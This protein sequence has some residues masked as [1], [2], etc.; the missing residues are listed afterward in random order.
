MKSAD[1]SVGLVL[2][3]DAFLR[4][5]L[6]QLNESGEILFEKLYV[7]ICSSGSKFFSRRSHLAF[8]VFVVCFALDIL[9]I[10]FDRVLMCCHL[11]TPSLMNKVENQP[12]I[13]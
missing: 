12:H 6:D 5:L 13:S 10:S 8:V 4:Q 9:A 2:V 7:L 11:W 3:D 1:P